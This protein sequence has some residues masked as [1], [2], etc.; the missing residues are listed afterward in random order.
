MKRNMFAVLACALLLATYAITS[1]MAWENKGIT[2]DE[3][4]HFV[5]AAVQVRESNFRIDPENLPLWKYYLALWNPAMNLKLGPP[6][7][8]DSRPM[9][10]SPSILQYVTDVIYRTPGNDAAAL[11]RT[12]RVRMLLVALVLGGLI[13]WWTWRL[14]GPLAAC[15]ATAAFSL[16]PNFLAHGPLVKNDLAIAMLF[17]TLSIVLWRIGRRATPANCTL[18]GVILG[19]AMCTKYSGILCIPVI[20]VLLFLRALD[21]APWQ[22][23]RFHASLFRARFLAGV[24]I[25][26]Y[27]I[28]LAWPVIWASFDFQYEPTRGVVSDLDRAVQT[29]AKS[30]TVCTYNVTLYTPAD[31]FRHEVGLWKP[32]HLVQSIRWIDSHHLLPQSFLTGFILAASFTQVR[33]SFLMGQLSLRGWWYYFPLAICFKTP[34]ATLLALALAAIANCFLPRPRN[35]WSL[36][37]LTVPP[38]IYMA[39]LMHSAVDIGIRHMFPVFAF[40]Y[41]LLGISVARA[42][43]RFGKPIIAVLAILFVGLGV[44]V[45][46]AFPN[47]IPFFNVAVG[48]SRGGAGLLSDSNIDWGQDLPALAKWQAGNPEYQLV[49][50]YFGSGDPE[51]YGIH[52]GSFAGSMAPIDEAGPTGQ[53][54]CWAVS[55]VGLQFGPHMNGTGQEE[56][57]SLRG[58]AP[59]EVLGGCIYLYYDP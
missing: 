49:L 53:K 12:G 8:G 11:I 44:E 52:Y 40:L 29:Y 38:I 51:Y 23:L 35:L 5:A 17:L 25:G 45:Y 36:C 43:R 41:I 4:V 34:V 27:A 42:F 3:P 37:A 24:A 6:P 14:A 56:F 32:D 26:L 21:P 50:Y 18:A 59:A 39:S 15:V 20:A 54:I 2:F 16:D 48:G 55:V 7:G 31:E 58:A 28:L 9:P 47:Y 30:D 33:Y 13:G 19:A 22:V 1:W 10:R 57:Q 46:A